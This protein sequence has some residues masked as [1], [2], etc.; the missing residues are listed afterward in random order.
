MINY[1]TDNLHFT[2]YLFNNITK[3][4]VNKMKTRFT[5]LLTMALTLGVVFSAQA[6]MS[7]NT[8]LISA[9]TVTE[10]N[11]T[12]EINN[13]ITAMLSVINLPVETKTIVKQLNNDALELKTNELVQETDSQLPKFK[14]KVVIA[15]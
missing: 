15:D 7:D 2:K 8:N 11:I 13:S 5:K 6:K 1:K 4:K 9:N 12:N 10:V 14:F 3:L